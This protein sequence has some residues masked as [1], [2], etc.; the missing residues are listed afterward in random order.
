MSRTKRKE[1][2]DMS[3]ETLRELGEWI[4]VGHLAV[5]AIVAMSVIYN[6]LGE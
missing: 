2:R 6:T 4:V 5:W 3:P 1:P